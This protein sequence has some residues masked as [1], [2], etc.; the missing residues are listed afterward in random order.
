MSNKSTKPTKPS[1]E[2]QKQQIL[3]AI[4]MERKSYFQLILGNLLRNESVMSEHYG[5]NADG[6]VITT[7]PDINDV[8]EMAMRGADHCIELMYNI[9]ADNS[10]G[11]E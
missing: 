3:R 7:K 4:T 2:A 8:V 1:P 11:N 10:D 6:K 5:E 9:K